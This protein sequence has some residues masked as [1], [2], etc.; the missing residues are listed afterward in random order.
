[1]RIYVA[2]KLN[3]LPCYYI[4]NMHQM[5]NYGEQLRRR[6]FSVFIP[7]L[8]ILPGIMF[9][10]WDYEDYF[11]NSQPWLEVSDILFVCPGWETSR[12]TKR[13]MLTAKELGI[14]I[15]YTMTEVEAVRE[16]VERGSDEPLL[17]LHEE[18]GVARDVPRLELAGSSI[19]DLGQEHLV[20]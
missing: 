8:E 12:G 5:I 3:A 9:G 20:E 18:S 4:R 15:C 17:G 16:R 11:Q 14:P 6:G 2:G 13:E 10:N 7:C 1:M 19:S